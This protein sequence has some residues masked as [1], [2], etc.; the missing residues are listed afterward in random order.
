MALL[1]PPISLCCWTLSLLLAITALEG[2]DNFIREKE[3]RDAFCVMVALP[4]VLSGLPVVAVV[5]P[6]HKMPGKC[7]DSSSV[8]M[9]CWDDWPH[10][11]DLCYLRVTWGGGEVESTEV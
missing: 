2:G 1:P 7:R 11:Q 5:C 4:A 3:A 9:E 10:K 6:D 8:R